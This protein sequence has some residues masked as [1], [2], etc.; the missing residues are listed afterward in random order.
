MPGTKRIL[1][2]NDTHCGHVLGLT[3]PGQQSPDFAE[4]QAPFYEFFRST[5][6]QIGHV[7]LLVGNGDL[8]DGP[9]RKNP[10]QSIRLDLG[11]QVKMASELMQNVDADRKVVVRGTGY[12]TDSGTSFED[13]V[14]KELDTEAYDEYRLE[15][16]GRRLHWRHVVGRSDIPY[17]QYTQVAKELINELLQAEMERY[18][19][20]DV[21]FRA[22]VHYCTGTSLLDA[23]TGYL[24][25]AWS[26]PA[27][28]LRGPRTGPY[29][30]GLRTW[31][32][33][34]GVTLIEIE[35]SGEIFVRP[36]GFPI[37]RYMRREYECLE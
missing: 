17:G 28:Q 21:L 14:A 15:V 2:I 29:P 18:D 19:A 37:K 23:E 34:V 32:Y 7:D 35:P 1:T 11:A 12:H 20:A 22:H 3:P 10:E 30:R 31:L 6:D 36:I 4:F 25:Q 24:R 5:V 26:L 27:L 9:Q 8:V 16:Y 33:H 13:F